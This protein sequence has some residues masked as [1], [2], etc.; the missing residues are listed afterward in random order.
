MAGGTDRHAADPGP[1]YTDRA[2]GLLIPIACNRI[3]FIEIVIRS[4][5]GRPDSPRPETP[6]SFSTDGSPAEN[7]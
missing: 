2:L 1:P 4:R 3:K 7:L 5:Q 6:P